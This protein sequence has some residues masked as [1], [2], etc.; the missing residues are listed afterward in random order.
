MFDSLSLSALFVV[1][2]TCAVI[3]GVA[4]TRLTYAAASLSRITGLGQA[5]FGAIFLGA[6]TSLPG[7]V[8]TVVAAYEGYTDLAISNAIGGIAAQTF[9]L[10]IADI[11]YRRSNLE[12]ASASLAAIVQATV[13]IAMLAVPLIFAELP[14]MKQSPVHIAT[15]ILLFAY[16]FG[17]RLARTARNYP[18]WKPK[19]TEETVFED[20]N[21]DEK[22]DAASKTALWVRFGILAAVVAGTGWVV[23][24]TGTRIADQS[25]FP[26][27][28]VGALFT[29]TVTSLPELV[30]T[31]AAA[32]HEAPT[33]AVSDIIGGNSFDVL[34]LV[35]ADL[36]FMDGSIYHQITGQHRFFIAVAMLMT[37]VF[38]LGMLR[39]E[40]HG[41]ANIGFESASLAAI[42]IGCMFALWQSS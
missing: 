38:V 36:A 1:L 41:F 2:G 13:L 4:G 34:F 6:I 17:M 39:R 26:P 25:S 29:A 16:I 3:I 42:Y 30:T 7:I 28:I 40:K 35:G 37:S 19:E 8:T 18:L 5:M 31:I 21:E 11:F 14:L 24:Q 12:H 9:F 32:R 15:P 20:T 22:G 23:A 10:A 27:V 33:L